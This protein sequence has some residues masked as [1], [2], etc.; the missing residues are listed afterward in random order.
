MGTTKGILLTC[1]A[2]ILFVNSAFAK[3]AEKPYQPWMF[4]VGGFSGYYNAGFQY[5]S[6]Y[7]S[8][9]G[10]NNV[11]NEAYANDVYQRGILG[12]SQ[13]GIQYHF[14]SPY[15]VALVFSYQMNANKAWLTEHVD[16]ALS[17]G[18]A[19][20]FDISTTNR[21]TDSYDIAPLFG[22]D[23][24][25]QT[26]L[27]AKVGASIANFSHTLVTTTAQSSSS[28]NAA[29]QAV[30][31]K[32][33]SGWLV[34]LGIS[35][36]FNRWLNF[37]G[38]YDY[39]NYGATNLDSYNDIAPLITGGDTDR[40]T[41]NVRTHASAFKLGL[42]IKFF[43]DMLSAARLM[44]LANPWMVYVGAF[45]GYYNAD[46]QY[47][48]NYFEIGGATTP[49]N[50][51]FNNDAL[52]HGIL[53]GL[54]AGIQYHFSSPYYV[55]LVTSLAL[56]ANK[57]RLTNLVDNPTSG[58]PI[59]SEIDI[60]SAFRNTETFE[61]APLFGMDIT[62]Q[63]RLYAKVGASVITFKNE[64]QTT[65][66]RPMPSPS[67]AFQALQNESF[68]G[69]LVGLGLSYDFNQW[70]NLFTE[71]DYYNYGS[72]NL[73]NLRNIS[74]NLTAA[75]VNL[76]TQH[77]RIHA[78]AFKVGLNVK[79][80]DSIVPHGVADLQPMA[81]SDS[82]MIY[83]GIFGGYYNT[84]FQY[85][86][87]YTSQSGGFLPPQTFV[88]NN[89]ASQQG[90]LGGAQGGVQY[91]FRNPYYVALAF[92]YVENANK[93][94]LVVLQADNIIAPPAGEGYSFNNSFRNQSNFDITPLFG[95]DITSFTHLYVKAG[96]SRA[97]FVHNI[98]VNVSNTAPFPNTLSQVTQF[99]GLWGW[100]AGVGLSYDF[101]KWL[102]LFGEYDYYNYGRYNLAAYTFAPQNFL[103]LLTQNVAA[104]SS[105]FHL[106]LNMTL[107]I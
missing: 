10:L 71:Y 78:S 68:W 50:Q 82:W 88:F 106:G 38:E 41:Q 12:G 5:G 30:Q 1:V 47:G 2:C 3:V 40:L 27:Y 13:L 84:D 45:S 79:F 94:R 19:A 99:K 49:G 11:G 34:G 76:L 100:T 66:V 8:S 20:A 7:F 61:I 42:N 59:N 74:N 86:A 9:G 4:Y 107:H 67:V 24:T 69:G 62:Q 56:N 55:G 105:A 64:L 70:L 21:I 53:G 102:N 31:S 23:V 63:T 77:V 28:P 35:H 98:V 15:Y 80:M 73:N 72:H 6:N 101:N 90:I 46:F 97:D 16:N 51:I 18:S 85:G 93:A 26:H 33:L 92:A 91:H 75:Q 81:L 54:Q 29:F 60:T 104:Y 25:A 39:Y 44:A 96:A 22:I 43:D 83:A 32:K 52:Q 36:D 103:D 17:A 65:Q 89:N 57:A 58:L 48:S 87:N 95:V 37:F 14:H